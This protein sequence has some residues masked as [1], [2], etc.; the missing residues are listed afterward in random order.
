MPSMEYSVGF[1]TTSG[2]DEA[3]KIATAL[4]GEKL[5]ACCNI[6]PVVE[7]IYRWEGKVSTDAEALMVIKT[8]RSLEKKVI[9]RVRELHSYTVPEVIFLSLRSGNPDYIKWLAES[10]GKAKE[11]VK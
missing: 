5:A 4:V 9:R 10:T 11:K 8:R 6:I 2:M 7:S 1:V 3:R